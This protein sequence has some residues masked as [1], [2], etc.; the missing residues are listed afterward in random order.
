M[1]HGSRKAVITAIISNGLVTVIKFFA[2]MV[3]GSASM[4]NEAVHSLMD[5]LNQAL[6]FAGLRESAKPA[7]QRYA[8]GH[9]QKKYLWNLWSAI[10]LFSIGAGLGL[11]HAW[12]SLH[13]GHETAPD[14]M[15][16]GFTLSPLWINL[17]VLA[18][19]FALEGYSF[20][21]AIKM[22]LR[23]MRAHGYTSP[24]RYLAEADDPTLV[25]VV[26]EDSVAMLGLALAATGIL[27]S[28]W[29]GNYLWDIGFSA[30]I[31][32]MLG[33]VA[34]FLGAVNMRFL[35]DMRDAQAEK[36]FVSV[37]DKHPEIERYH[38]LRSIIM[39]EEHTVLVAE[40]ELREEMVTA[41]LFARI[42][43]ERL[44]ILDS[45]PG[46]KRDDEAVRKY[47]MTRA[48]VQVTLA[49]V[50]EIIDEIE[51]EIKAIVPR[52]AHITLETEGISGRPEEVAPPVA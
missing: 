13:Q 40:V 27:L 51:A 2:A 10:G 17:I 43:A 11:M 37:V 48:S 34:F 4:L 50:E 1:A 38:D 49:R 32:V 47:A 36:A 24:F 19:A 12:H 20:F 3:S 31:A 5:T 33:F 6:L 46:A 39:D 42:E 16:A 41:G 21:V 18:I 35:A 30:L 52:V 7:D 23:S 8:F 9:A 28:H 26:L 15:I 29:S 14:V 44:R 45:V 22:C 25:A